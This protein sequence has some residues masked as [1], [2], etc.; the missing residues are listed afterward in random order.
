M[1]ATPKEVNRVS[2]IVIKAKIE[3]AEARSEAAKGME[4]IQSMMTHANNWQM[5]Y[6]QQEIYNFSH[7]L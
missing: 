2:K 3:A 5:N 6:A 1:Q 4:Q 7:P